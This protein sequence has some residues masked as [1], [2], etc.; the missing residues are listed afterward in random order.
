[1]EGLKTFLQE[2][3]PNGEKVVDETHDENK[4]NVNHDFIDSNV[5]L[6]TYHIPKIDMRKF[7]GKDPVTWILQM[8]QYFDLHNVQNTQ[9]VC[10]ATLYLEQNTFV[11][12]RWLCSHKQI[13]TW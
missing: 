11:W 7:D 8:E 12:Y 1:M 2:M 3:I 4:R 5:L 13:V 6:N 9:K 10:I